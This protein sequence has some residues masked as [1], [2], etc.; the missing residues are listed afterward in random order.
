MKSIRNQGS[1]LCFGIIVIVLALIPLLYQCGM[2][3]ASSTVLFI[4]KCMAFA[5]VAIGLDLIW[6]Y[7]GILSLGQEFYFA[8][9]G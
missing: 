9:G 6:G 4:G 2:F 8:L 1:N 7:T 3:T 5:I